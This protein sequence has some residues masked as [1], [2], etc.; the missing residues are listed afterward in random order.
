MLFFFKS[1]HYSNVSRTEIVD[2][3]SFSKIFELIINILIHCNLQADYVSK[4]NCDSF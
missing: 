1:E 2:Q 3:E 4:I